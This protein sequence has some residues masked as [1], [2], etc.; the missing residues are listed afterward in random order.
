[1]LDIFIAI[2]ARTEIFKIENMQRQDLQAFLYLK[3]QNICTHQDK[4]Q[5][6]TQNYPVTE[7]CKI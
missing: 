1:M 2:I 3:I 5:N 7:S 6:K 4:N